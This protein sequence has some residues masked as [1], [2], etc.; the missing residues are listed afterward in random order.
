MN[1]HITHGRVTRWLLLL[2]EFNITVI[3][4]PSKENQVAYFLS[5]I[6]TFG[7]N[8]PIVDSFLDEKLFAISIKSPWFADIANYLSLGKL[9]PYFSSREKRQVIKQSARYSWIR[10]DLFYTGNDLITKR[11]IREDEVLDIL[12]SCHDESCGGHFADKRTT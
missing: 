2:Q 6:N 8:V 7:E 12:K 11:C 9:P 4:R 10:G 1:K 3:D 5:C